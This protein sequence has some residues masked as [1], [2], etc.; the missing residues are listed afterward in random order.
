MDM[1]RELAG[2]VSRHSFLMGMAGLA[3]TTGSGNL[4]AAAS[5]AREAAA[6]RPAS[7]DDSRPGVVT[8]DLSQATGK[9]VQPWLYGYA[10]GALL[11]NNFRLAADASAEMSAE[12][13]SPALIRLNTPVQ[14]IVQS[15]FA[16]GVSAPDWTPFSPWQRHRGDFLGK[17]GRLIFG[18]GPAGD[19]TSIPPAT[20]AE[21]AKATALHF[22]EIGQEITYWE[23]G[24]EC[25]RMGA[26][27]YSRYFNA[28]ADALHSVNP[29][30]LVGGPV[31][32]WWN[33]ID[34]GAFVRHSGARIGFIDFHS[35]P[36]DDTDSVQ[37]AYEKA[38]TLADVRSARQAV[39]GTVAANL[40]IGL[41]EYNLN[42]GQ[43]PNGAWGLPAQGRITGAVYVA[44]LLTRAFTSDP[45]FT[46][47][48]LWDLIANSNYGAIGN[49]QDGGR[50][51]SIDEQ[52]W[53][54]RQAAKLMPGQQVHGAT[55]TPDLQ[56]LASTTGTHYSVQVVNYNLSAARSVTVTVTGAMP[57]SQVS[58]WELSARYPRGKLSTVPGLAR[59]TVPPQSIVILHGRRGNTG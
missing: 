8:V 51:S 9:T 40:P 45:R 57:K 15:V 54:L 18:I 26:A 53:Y 7:P 14:T 10:S 28:I 32:S 20:W 33:G 44:L 42:G 5:S 37:A 48:G 55:T 24:N 12:T 52:G 56:L 35:Y 1:E 36:V 50:Y 41:L 23:A 43:Q 58:R 27:L 13:L 17:G 2:P 11:D 22:R 19:D 47:A 16:K 49:A 31:A 34:L 38:A 46:M 29:A 30:Y 21:Y 6:A 25:D 3:V 39:S 59:V 4:R